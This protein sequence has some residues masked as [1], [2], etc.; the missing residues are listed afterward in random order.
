[1]EIE[2][3]C[4]SPND[5]AYV[6]LIYPSARA[7]HSF[8]PNYQM[9]P[10][11]SAILNSVS[12]VLSP[13]DAAGGEMEV[14]DLSSE[15]IV[16]GGELVFSLHVVDRRLMLNSDS[17]DTC[18]RS[19][20]SRSYWN[21]VLSLRDAS[22]WSHYNNHAQPHLD[23]AITAFS[24]PNEIERR[25]LGSQRLSQCPTDNPLSHTGIKLKALSC[26]PNSMQMSISWLTVY[27]YCSV[28]R[29]QQTCKFDDG[30]SNV[31]SGAS[32]IDGEI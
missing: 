11:I 16:A 17:S 22:P 32:S 29:Q 24:F 25:T 12:Y 20:H 3:V 13:Q 15:K 5:H 10:P 6:P 4:R 1:M 21:T 27:R 9:L 23:A 30:S 31:A 7:F 2:S 28:Q 18:E 8:Q 14:S 26:E 19:A